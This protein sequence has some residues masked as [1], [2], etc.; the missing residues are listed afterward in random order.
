MIKKSILKSLASSEI[1]SIAELARLS[2]V[3]EASL[4]EFLSGKRK[5]ISIIYLERIMIVLELHVAC[6]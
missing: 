5:N 4:S 2:K 6:Y 1:N 3:R